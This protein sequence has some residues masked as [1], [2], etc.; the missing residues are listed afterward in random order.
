MTDSQQEKQR[1]KSVQSETNTSSVGKLEASVHCSTQCMNTECDIHVL[2]S[3]NTCSFSLPLS[4][5]LS[6]SIPASSSRRLKSKPSPSQ[7][8]L[9][10][11]RPQ[12]CQPEARMVV[13]EQPP[14][15]NEVEN[16]EDTRQQ[17]GVC[18]TYFSRLG[19]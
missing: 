15:I 14:M 8:H 17:G 7:R 16:E 6:L 12:A 18:V 4:L 5:S 3:T 2:R 9:R 10:R 1:T 11:A 19:T 13:L